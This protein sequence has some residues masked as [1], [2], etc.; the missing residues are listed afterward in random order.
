MRKSSERRIVDFLSIL[1]SASSSG[2]VS[3]Q[4][5]ARRARISRSAVW[6]HIRQLRRRGYGIDSVHGL[7]Y[8]MVSQ[9]GAP[10]PWELKKRL[11]T[12]TVGKQIIYRDTGDSTQSVAL[13][14]ANKSPDADGTVIIFE[15]QKIGRG[16][17]K[18][19]WLSPPGGLWLSVILKPRVETAAITI[20]PLV[21]ALAVREAIAETTGLGASLKWPNDVMVSGRKVAG[22]LLDVSA[23]AE[24]LN[25][26]VFGIG[27]NANVNSK[28]IATKVAATQEITSLKNELGRDVDRLELAVA[29]LQNLEHHMD[30]FISGGPGP[31]IS[32]W[33]RNTELLGRRITVL[34]DGKEIQHFVAADV[35][36]DGSLVVVSESG[37]KSRLTSGDVRIRT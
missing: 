15:N 17:L 25:Y 3:G 23:E 9:T 19:K 26:A 2:Y 27:I 14:I 1:E 37:E 13:S 32:A 18:R 12:H 36:A 31:V 22:I 10:V 35:D 28:D 4:L 8:R 11:K 29:V 6:K 16:R 5:L 20:L 30:R 7:G 34:Q 33:K 21:A 24:T